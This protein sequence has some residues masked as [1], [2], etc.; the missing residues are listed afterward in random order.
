MKKILLTV[1]AAVVVI[2]VGI[3]TYNKFS[4]GRFAS[5]EVNKTFKIDIAFPDLAEEE[6]SDRE[7][8]DQARDWLLY[9]II[10]NSGLKSKEIS[11]ATFDLA[12][13]RYGFN[14][15]LS[16]SIMAIQDP[17]TSVPEALC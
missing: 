3:F 12:P 4:N 9:T 14:T 2:A 13:V 8:A 10:T 11:E 7:K 6:F 1:L 17:N 16:I 5:M 15:A